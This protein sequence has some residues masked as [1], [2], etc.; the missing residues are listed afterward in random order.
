MLEARLSFQWKK[1]GLNNKFKLPKII[2]HRGVKNL[3]PENSIESISKAFE[4]GLDCVEIDVK[5]SKD[6]IPLLI[7]DDTLDRTTT[8]SGLV[9]KF[10]FDEISNFDAGY[11]FYNS[12]T[13]IRVPSLKKVL[14]E[15]TNKKKSVNIELKPNKGLEKLNVEKVV[16][17]IKDFSLENVFFSSFDLG[18]CISLKEKLP[19]AFCGFLNHDFSKINVSD[20]I[21]ICK[22]YDFFS[23]GTDYKSFSDSIVNELLNNDILVTVYSGKN[24]P[25]KEAQKLWNKNVSSVFVDDPSEYLN[26]S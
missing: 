11:F 21:D 12:K 15:I 16:N 23:C 19:D 25:K 17:E 20:T 24:I 4:L 5:I 8:G 7:H 6:H 13:T 26:Y 14:N 3:S 22:R 10:T 18:S 1:L 2:G 9:C